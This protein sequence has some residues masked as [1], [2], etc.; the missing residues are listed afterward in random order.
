MVI[1]SPMVLHRPFEPTH[2]D[3][4]GVRDLLTYQPAGRYW[5]FQWYELAI[6]IVLALLLAGSCLWWVR[7][8]LA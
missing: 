6:F 3:Q 2:L 4:L 7:H 1:D 5:P 8:R